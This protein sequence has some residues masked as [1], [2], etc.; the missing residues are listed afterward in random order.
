MT[1]ERPGSI[2]RKPIRATRAS[3]TPPVS[4][5]SVQGLL[6]GLD[7][8]QRRAVTHRRGP[9]LV[10]AGP[11]TGKTEV[12]TRRIAWLIATRRARPQ[13]ILALTFTDKAATEM[14]ARVDLLVPYGQAESAIHTFHA[15]G[16]QVLREFGHE[17]GLPDAP[18]V[19]GRA[20]QVVLLREHLFGLGLDRYLPLG[21]PT[22]FLGSL[23]DLFGRAKDSGVTPEHLAGYAA[24]LDAG[25]RAALSGAPDDASRTAANTLVDEAV[26]QQE[27]AT[28]YAR[29]QDLMMDRGLLD[30]GDQVSLA[31]RLMRERPSV[32]GVLTDRFRYV[33]VD[34]AQDIDHVQ[35]ELIR[36]LAVHRELTLVGDDD[37]A[38]YTFRGAA[39]EHLMDLGDDRDMQRI[40]LRTSHRS[41]APILT[42][43]R[44]L[45]RHNDPYRLEVRH[46]L[47]KRL[48]P[49]RRP[50]RPMPVREMA[51]RT[52]AEEADGIA[53]E[54]AARI[55]SGERASEFAVLVRTNSDAVPI[56][57]SL[58]LQG[59]PS[60]TANATRLVAAP[61]VRELLATLRVVG[62]P[63]SSTDLYAM[64]TGQPYGLGGEDLTAVLGMASRRHRSLWSVMREVL[65]QPGL[66]RLSGPS[67]AAIGRLVEDVRTAIESS[68]V[69]PAG[70]VLYGHLRRS[71]RYSGLV[72]AAE[73][74]DD[75]PLRR[76][77]RLFEIISS[78]SALLADPRLANVLPHLRALLDTGEEVEGDDL[79]AHVDAVS[80]LTVHKAKGL[81]FKVVF[82]PGLVDGR[83]PMR[84]RPD[85]LA[86]PSALRT[87]GT[88]EEAPFAE[89][90]RLCFVAMTRARDELILSHAVESASARTRRPSPFIA[91]ALDRPASVPAARLP[92]L[93][94][95]RALPVSGPAAVATAVVSATGSLTLSHSQVDDYLSCP[96]KYR[97][98]HVARVPTPPH[99]ALV[100]GNALHQ[101]AAAWHLAEL[102][103]RPLDIAGVLDAFSAHWSSEGFLSRHH[104]DA[105]FAAGQQALRRLVGSV[106][107]PARR[108]VAVERSFQ[109]RLGGDIVRGR[110][111]RVD[112]SAG[113]AIITDYKSSDVRDQHRADERARDSL[114]LQ[115]YALAWE[116]ETGELPQRMELHFLDSGVVGRVSPET[117]R[118][119]RARRL[120]SQAADGI[121]SGSF[122]AKPDMIGCGYCPY[123]EICPSSAA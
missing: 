107:D 99:H 116:A 5:D 95:F 79:D 18:R 77:A 58:E 12:I 17:L 96:L 36:L 3:A 28:A 42:A 97:L 54:I 114:Q 80:V 117:R 78:R 115:V 57:H 101:A 109:V 100:L 14:Q 19:I 102:R 38:I 119:D 13:Q 75:G 31:S 50:R 118:L 40:V 71:G 62:D 1:A 22:R 4:L 9:L 2:D 15:F 41:H 98:R 26:G 44:R 48:R 121:R 32:A 65:E 89:E 94:V 33:L 45:I 64:A 8:D 16:D 81:E 83:F 122:P 46:G 52:T 49:R 106:P 69:E 76:V 29:Y 85:R 60:R 90:R 30:F 56:L 104:E 67:R 91:E 105:R 110:Y 93:D 113:G 111:D 27:L 21:D 55:G 23:A 51:F 11:G 24:A 87:G 20:D 25:A 120:L 7:R 88:Q 74:G 73:R 47:D 35:L 34:E 72:A 86:L 39:G 43:A 84:G 66:L 112:E 6:R 108:T 123:R 103:G 37:Q 63:D 82:L 70:N 61:E 68:H 92:D 10:V 59:V 53:L